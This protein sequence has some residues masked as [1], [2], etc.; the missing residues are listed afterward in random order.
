M[1]KPCIYSK[2]YTERIFLLN[3]KVLAEKWSSVMTEVG[4]RGFMVFHEFCAHASVCMRLYMYV[5]VCV[6]VYG[7]VWFDQYEHPMDPSVRAS[8]TGTRVCLR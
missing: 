7:R 6:S 1:S 4:E 5:C 8:H 3:L 2:V